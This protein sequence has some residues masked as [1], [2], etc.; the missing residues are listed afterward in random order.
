[1]KSTIRSDQ[2][3]DEGEAMAMIMVN[4]AVADSPMCECRQEWSRRKLEISAMMV[5]DNAVADLP[6]CRCGSVAV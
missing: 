3:I 6:M 4:D 5:G 1:M 2:D